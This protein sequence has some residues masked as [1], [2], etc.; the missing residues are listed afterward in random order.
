MNLVQMK[1]R[2]IYLQNEWPF[3]LK[4]HENHRQRRLPIY[5]DTERTRILEITV[6]E[7]FK[8]YFEDAESKKKK[9]FYK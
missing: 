8:P 4:V 3:S 6:K 5:S 2:S 9:S 7:F 1:G